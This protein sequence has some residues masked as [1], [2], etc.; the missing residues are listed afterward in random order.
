M[1]QVLVRGAR[2]A[3]LRAYFLHRMASRGAPPIPEK[4][5]LPRVHVAHRLFHDC[6]DLARRFVDLFIYAGDPAL[7]E[8][9]Y[10]GF[11]R[12]A[13]WCNL[14]R[15]FEGMGPR[16]SG[17]DKIPVV[18]KQPVGVAVDLKNL[19]CPANCLARELQ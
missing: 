11:N 17:E 10:D 3:Q 2:D 16:E 6:N 5:T 18:L 19:L 13:G 14:N 8:Q 4:S 9:E 12:R 7:G 1:T 15:L